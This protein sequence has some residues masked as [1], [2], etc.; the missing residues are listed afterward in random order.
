MTPEQRQ[1]S[2]INEKINTVLSRHIVPLFIDR[3]D[4]RPQSCGTGF[5]VSS[6]ASSF[7][8]TA[9][10]VLDEIGEGRDVYFYI[11]Q[12]TKLSLSFFPALS[13]LPE[14]KDRDQDILDVGVLQLPV[15]HQPPY[16][17][18]DK[19]PLNV[20]SLLPNALPREGK[21]Y[22]VLGFP[23]SHGR[24]NHKKPEIESEPYSFTNISHPT[25]KYK[26]IGVK[27][28]SHIAIIFDRKR[29]VGPDGKRRPFP[30][31]KGMSGSPVWLLYDEQE[32]LNAPKQI[33]VVGVF[34]ERRKDHERAMLVTDIGLALTMIRAFQ[35]RTNAA[36][37]LKWDLT[38]AP[39]D[40]AEEIRV[41]YRPGQ[42]TVDELQKM[43]KDGITAAMTEVE[44]SWVNIANT[45][46]ANE[47]EACAM[48]ADEMKAEMAQRSDK[49]QYGQTPIEVAE[50]I[51]AEIRA[52]GN[53]E[54]PI[55]S[56]MRRFKG[57]SEDS[58]S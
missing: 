42:Q 15:S 34:I 6:N 36:A 35:E 54:N 52:R 20:G 50:Y 29:S 18:V 10:H 46:L 9:A 22:R 24:V 58:D 12:K 32:E 1:A 38:I 23:G 41:R 16:P 56:A 51:A 7:L 25:E 4:G 55:E 49:L 45:A 14:G 48:I 21:T 30:N 37:V 11:E 5:L 8:I 26:K 53:Q 3:S 17:A 19:W 43:I 40:R 31:P 57:H 33:L 2:E 44:K 39:E 13:T 47:R 27:P 28:E